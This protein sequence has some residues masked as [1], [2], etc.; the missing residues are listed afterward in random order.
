MVF[1]LLESTDSNNNLAVDFGCQRGLLM[2]YLCSKYKKVIGVDINK[3]VLDDADKILKNENLNNYRL[4]EIDKNSKKLPFKDKS[5]DII[6]CTDVLEHVHNLDEVLKEFSRILKK[7]G[8]LVLSVPTENLFYR[9]GNLVDY[10]LC[11]SKK[12]VDADHINNISE[13]KTKSSSDFKVF[14]SK[15]LLFCFWIALLRRK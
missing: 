15:N 6:A 2:T 7:T 10:K 4:I 3:E 5:V 8:Y 1:D 11:F 14:R 13:I 12:S 9:L